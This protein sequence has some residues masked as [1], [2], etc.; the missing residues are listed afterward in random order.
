MEVN[1]YAFFA[2]TVDRNEWLDSLRGR[3]TPWE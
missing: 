1:L 3:F 2:L